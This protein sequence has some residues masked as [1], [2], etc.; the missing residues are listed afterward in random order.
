ME[1]P[2]SITMLNDFV[3]CPISIYFHNLY[4][5][6][7]RNLYQGKSQINGTK[8]HETIDNS[9]LKNSKTL[10]YAKEVYCE[11][12]NLFGKIDCYNVQNKTLIERKKRVFTIYDG[13][14]Y[15]LYAQYFAMTEMGYAVEK[16]VIHSI[17]D[18]KNYVIDL[19]NQNQIMLQKFENII[20]QINDFE[21]DNYRQTNPEKCKKCIYSSYCD[22]EVK[23]NDVY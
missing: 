23:D 11:K 14:V 8:A 10:I 5:G 19:P 18:N 21:I 12:Y 2:I 16:L 22:R 7:E 4:D 9:T 17:D 6:V 13:Y 15:Q 20:L 3:F 1:S